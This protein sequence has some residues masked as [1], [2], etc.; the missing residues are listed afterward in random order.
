MN[1]NKLLLTL[2]AVA[3]TLT[4]AT[5]SFAIFP[6]PDFRPNGFGYLEYDLQLG[7][8]KDPVSGNNTQAW[9]INQDISTNNI[10]FAR[11]AAP[12][13]WLSSKLSSALTPK[14]PGGKIAA[15][16][17]Y[18]VLN[19]KKTQGP[20]FSTT[21]GQSD[22]SGLW[23]VFYITWLPG[24]TPRA[25]LNS[26]PESPTNPTG[27]P[28]ALE[29][30]IVAQ[31]IVIQLPIVA[32]GP[33][34][35]PWLPA[36][37]GTYRMKQIV[38][39]KDYAREKEVALPTFLVFCADCV[40]NKVEK[41]IVTIP[42]VSDEA[43]A[44]KLGANLAPGL[45]NMPDSD[46]QAFYNILKS[47]QLCQLPVI[48]ECPKQRAERQMC[49]GFTPIVR[50]T[51][52]DRSV[53]LPF[54]TVINNDKFVELLLGKSLLTVADDDKRMGL[55]FFNELRIKKMLDPTP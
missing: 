32:L 40:T 2:L 23:Q 33:L 47:P 25:I 15:R 22:Y 38:V 26:D 3:I 41:F 17:M 12:F 8:V 4:V 14:D 48:Q 49:E 27:L 52:L 21:P 39:E 28:T 31:D 9:Y 29:A 34:G 10:N 44:T 18:I 6:K 51:D 37:A 35:G 20:V 11:Y 7:S 43:L 36:P 5:A 13:S 55:L 45:L 1:K 53:N 30:D 16:P 42:D 46:T 54:S 50:L 19:P 24:S